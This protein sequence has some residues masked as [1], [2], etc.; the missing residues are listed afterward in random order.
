MRLSCTAFQRAGHQPAGCQSQSC[1][2]ADAVVR[3]RGTAAHS[4]TLSAPACNLGISTEYA[5]Q[6]RTTRPL[7]LHASKEITMHISR[8]SFI[9]AT[10]ASGIAAAFGGL[11]LSLVPSV[12]HAKLL[13]LRWAKQ[14]TSVCCFCA[15]GCGLLVHTDKTSHRAVNVE[16]NPDHPVNEGS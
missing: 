10:A 7:T 9:K 6:P 14:T 8:R 13:P 4:L 16:G 15:V 3:H 2:T 1:H 5:V 12:S 11:G